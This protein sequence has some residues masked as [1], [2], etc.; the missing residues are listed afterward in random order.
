MPV[1]EAA[2]AADCALLPVARLAALPAAAQRPLAAQRVLW[3]EEG[4]EE[5][6]VEWK[7][8]LVVVLSSVCLWA[9]ETRCSGLH[10]VLGRNEEDE[11]DGWVEREN[12]EERQATFPDPVVAEALW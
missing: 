5:G 2:A 10:D 3:E 12:E 1:G 11:D 6:A 8:H 7:A 4:E 9:E